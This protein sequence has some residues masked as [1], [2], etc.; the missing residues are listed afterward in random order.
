M[1]A[2]LQEVGVRVSGSLTTQEL[3]PRSPA[4]PLSVFDSVCREL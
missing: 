4:P 2:D 1:L 3:E